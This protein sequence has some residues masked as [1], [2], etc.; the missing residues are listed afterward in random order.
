MPRIPILGGAY[1]SRSIISGSQ[2]C[3]NLYPEKNDDP[4]A[5]V[6]VTHYPT[7][8]LTLKGTPTTAGPARCLYRATNGDLFE[9]IR[10]SVYFISALFQYQKLGELEGASPTIVS[11]VDNGIAVL[12]VDGSELGYAIKLNTHEFKQVNDPNFLGGTRVDYMDTYFMLNVPGTRSWYISLPQVTFENLTAGAI[13]PPNIY[14]AFDPLDI[15]AKTGSADSIVSVIAMHRNP[16]LVGALT[17]EIWYNSGAADFT[18]GSIPGV[19]IEHGCVAPYSVARQDLSVFWL[20]QDREGKAIILRGSAD[21]SISELSSK[22]IEAIITDMPEITDAIGG[23]FQQNGHAFYVLTFPTAN[24]TFAVELKTGQWHELAW[25]DGNG[26][27]NRHRANCWAFAY[28]LNLVADWQN[29]KVYQLDPNAFTDFGGPI[30]RLRTVPHMLND[31][32]QARMDKIMADL[33]GG[34]L[35]SATPDNPPKVYLRTSTDRGASFG[36][37]R[38]GEFGAAGDYSQFPTWRNC[39][40]ARDFVHEISWS[41]PINTVFNGLFYEATPADQ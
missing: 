23:C 10:S 15:A 29:G 39:G 40:L 24:R 6:P 18:F 3:I 8:G 35:T 19:F 27:L 2:R 37:A 30:T 12:I 28:G 38:E 21:Y 41:E 11:M 7:P 36:N 34:T 32:K 1:Q 16:W 26:N 13:T 25:T 22:G 14:A 33:Q 17:S 4:Q 31:G 9:V 5:P 20:S